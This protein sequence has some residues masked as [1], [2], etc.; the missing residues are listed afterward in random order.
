MSTHST[1][2]D[3][4]RPLSSQIVSLET[5]IYVGLSSAKANDLWD[6]WTNWSLTGP[7]RETD[8]DDGF[9]LTVTFLDFI[10]G[11]CSVE[12]TVDTTAE[13]NIE[14]RKCLDACSINTAT[15]DAIMDP[16]FRKLRLSNSCLYWAKDTIEMR[17]KGLESHQQLGTARIEVDVWSPPNAMAVLDAPGYTTLLQSHR[18]SPDTKAL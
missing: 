16:K 3:F 18:P 12:H 6:R 15:Q 2:S 1:Y 7:R 10:I 13:D 17:Y 9:G 14:W 11:G 8:P 5:L 4:G